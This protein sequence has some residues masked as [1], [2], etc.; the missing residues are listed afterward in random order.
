MKVLDT[1]LRDGSYA[2]NFKFSSQ[3][4]YN[5]S[6]ALDDT[7]IDLIEVEHGVGHNT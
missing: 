2:I 6:K 3:Q 7:G 1:T 4:T 5:I